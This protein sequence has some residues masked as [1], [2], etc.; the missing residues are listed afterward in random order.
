[1]HFNFK[2]DHETYKSLYQ[3]KKKK[4]QKCLEQF[5]IIFNKNLKNYFLLNHSILFPNHS[6]L[7]AII[8]VFVSESGLVLMKSVSMNVTGE[9][10]EREEL[11]E[12]KYFISV[13]VIKLQE[14]LSSG[15]ISKLLDFQEALQNCLCSYYYFCFYYCV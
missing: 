1:M 4:K 9:N 6:I 7:S 15:I 10:K 13:S 14:S 12:E 11:E 8:Y 2:C 3:K 5:G